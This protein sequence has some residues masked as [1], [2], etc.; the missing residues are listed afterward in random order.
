VRRR[1]LHL[2]E[3]SPLAYRD[4]AAQY[5]A[6]LSAYCELAERHVDLCQRYFGTVGGEGHAWPPPLS[7]KTP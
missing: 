4:L 5:T 7:R 1:T 3:V 2:R 6:L